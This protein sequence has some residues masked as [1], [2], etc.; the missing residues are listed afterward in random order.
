M[1]EMNEA[2]GRELYRVMFTARCIDEMEAELVARAEAFFHVSGAGHEG[3]AVLHSFLTPDDFLHLHY[4]DKAL[5]LARGILPE[6]FFHSLLCNAESH[7]MGRQMSAHMSDPSR[8]ILSLVGPVGNHAL[9]AVGVASVT[10][11]HGHGSIVLCSMGDGTSQ[12]GEVYEA[13]AEA[14]R[15]QLP[16]LFLIENNR[17]S[18]STTTRGNTFFSRPEGDA[19]E[20][21]GLP[22]HRL[23]GRDVV[24]CHA[25]IGPIIDSVRRAQPAI[26]I[27]EVERLS[28]HTNADDERVYRG[29]T[30]IRTAAEGGDPLK[31]LGRHLIDTGVS[32]AELE[33]I[34]QSVRA[35]V[36]AAA[37][38]A[39]AAS[40]PAAVKEAKRSLPP[41][42]TD[43]VVEVVN[44]QGSPTL[45]M[46]EAI[47]E[48]LR[49]RLASDPRVT[50][51]GE[52]I[53]DPKG[54]VFGVTR[55]LSQAFA[56][57]VV[58]SAL[59]ESTIVGVSIGQALAGGR[60]VAFIQFADF[61]PLA[62][63]QII[64]EMGSMY[65]R[66]AGGW[67]CPAI[68]MVACGGYRPGLGPF[69]AQT[70][71]SIMAHVP[72]IDVL[73][74][75]NAPD[76]AGLLNAAF[77]S[78]RPTV[79]FYPKVCLN[80]R[81][82]L[83]PADV[84]GRIEPIGHARFLS[85]GSDLTMV[86]WGSPVSIGRKV[87][88]ALR[89]VEVSVDLI[90]LRSISPWDHDAVCQSAAKTGR[91]MVIHEDNLTAG[92]GAEVIA[93]VCEAVSRKL[94]VR[95]IT[96]PDTYVPCK[97]ANQL[98]ILP[99]FKRVLAAAA[100][101]LDLD[102]AWTMNAPAEEGWEFV[103]AIG[104]SPADRTVTV[105]GWQVVAGQSVAAGDIIAEMEADKAVLD[106]ACPT[107]GVV[108]EVL[109][110]PGDSVPVGTPLL[111]LRPFLP[112][113][114]VR[115]TVL[116]QRGEPILRRKPR[117]GSSEPAREE[118]ALQN[119]RPVVGISS[120]YTEEGSVIVTNQVLAARFAPRTAEHI[121]RL[122]GIQSRRHLT[123][124]QTV[125][126]MA[127][128]AAKKALAG[129]GLS[130]ADLDA[131]FCST[132]T[133][134]DITPSLAC[135]LQVELCTDR[136]TCNVLAYDILAACSGYLYA[137][138][139]GF[140]FLQANP[141]ATVLVITAEAMSKVVDPDD[142]DTAVLFGDAATAT[143]LYGRSGLH[144]SKALLHRP[145]VSA[146]P[147]RERTLRIPNAASGFV[148]MRGRKVFGEA[149]RTMVNTLEQACA[150]SALKLEDL[151]FIIPHQANGRII[152]AVRSRLGAAAD[153][154]VNNIQARGNTSSSTIPLCLAEIGPQLEAGRPIGLCAFGGGFTF[155][156]AI[157][158]SPPPHH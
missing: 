90:D 16:V 123:N 63:N 77:E 136:E 68:V 141:G 29:D 97:F 40:S 49:H 92:F 18:I 156:A 140:D 66:T 78:G 142:F 61:L 5:M 101:L 100:E 22:L 93:T 47:R 129:E 53:E 50:L 109:V 87:V 1:K 131:I 48:V 135:S 95:R 89:S 110:R 3:S 152:E 14:V 41:R 55:G 11:A 13:I 130:I 91:L 57:R 146:K 62:F 46:L 120:V 23:N 83:A 74:P 118:S 111:K 102:L 107:S 37:E 34:E 2:Y 96:R 81:E 69:H 104:A 20:F 85:Q 148:E 134:V 139:A 80:A 38:R 12:Q 127:A 155:G 59:S 105:I 94:S 67:E 43:S 137:L 153:R 9:Q 42:L 30:E 82:N 6:Q 99:S 72:G 147:D 157:V 31:N 75:S 121:Y 71:E 98:E 19:N 33:A 144:R 27:L 106:L 154:V 35:D 88:D 52:D 24:S 4:R 128:A 84:A 108:E 158:E 65:W 126:S 73:M 8:R 79:F 86:T 119:G 56:G 64:S 149:V 117:A 143:I 44:G 26:V 21:Y 145:V 32:P 133:P 54:D 10:K 115:Q 125:L 138:S 25:T 17:Y 151:Q 45:T 116:M 15:S 39:L 124:E 132:S 7:S 51:L 113:S 122:T 76:A 112:A 28:D 60:P 103:K 114:R 70:M 58:N 150:K 36:E